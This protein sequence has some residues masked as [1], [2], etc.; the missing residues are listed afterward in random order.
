MAESNTVAVLLPVSNYFIKEN[1]KPPIAAFRA[2]GVPMALATNCN[3]GSSPCTSVLLAMNM[4]CTLFG[5]SPEEALAG[6]TRVGA[7]AL[8]L[9]RDRGTVAAGM[10]AD[11]CVWDVAGPNE[12]AYYL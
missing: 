1:Q 11:L 4:G 10:R 5:L 9:H 8:G 6:V 12:L 3:P 7:R 2:A